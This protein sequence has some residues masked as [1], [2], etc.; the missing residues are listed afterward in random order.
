MTREEAVE[1]IEEYK[2]VVCRTFTNIFATGIVFAIQGPAIEKVLG[3]EPD[4]L[5]KEMNPKLKEMIAASI[6]FVDVLTAAAN[7]TLV[8]ENDVLSVEVLCD[9]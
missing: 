3:L 8:A 1:A 6:A 2:M 4:A 7:G 9:E 5:A